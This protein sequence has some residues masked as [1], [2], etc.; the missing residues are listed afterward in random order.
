VVRKLDRLGRNAIDVA[1]TVTKLAAE[2]TT[3][4][5]QSFIWVIGGDRDALWRNGRSA[6]GDGAV[7]SGAAFRFSLP[8][9]APGIDSQT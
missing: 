1:Q 3:T 5:V 9:S 2:L 6:E 7:A 4:D 8:G